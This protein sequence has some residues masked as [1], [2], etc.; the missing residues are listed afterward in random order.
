MLDDLIKRYEAGERNPELIQALNDAAWTGFH[1]PWEQT[2][3]KVKAP[4][5]EQGG[6]MDMETVQPFTLETIE[7]HLKGKDISYWK[8]DREICLVF[9]GY[10]KVSDRGIRAMHFVEGRQNTVYRLRIVADR[11]VD[12]KDY[13]K[14]HELCDKWN[15]NYRWPRAYL[16]IGAPDEKDGEPD[17]GVLAMD[18]QLLLDKGIHQALFDDLVSDAIATSWAFWKMA[19]EKFNL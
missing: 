5:E 3:P 17:S 2:P 15:A 12:A 9:L 19:R 11:R 6:T 16:E 8:T 18:Y 14:A 1:D 10:D 4:P 13:P 7:R